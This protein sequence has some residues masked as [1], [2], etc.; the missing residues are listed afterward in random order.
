MIDFN[1]RLASCLMYKIHIKK[2]SAYLC[3]VKLVSH[4]YNIWKKEMS[5]FIPNVKSHGQ[6]TFNYCSFKYWNI[7]P[8]LRLGLFKTLHTIGL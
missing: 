3:D 5:Y 4:S 7:K 1:I 2:A 8:K 6:Q